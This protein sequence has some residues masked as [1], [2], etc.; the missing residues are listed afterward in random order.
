R[1]ELLEARGLAERAAG[2][3]VEAIALH[4]RAQERFV[5]AGQP[6]LAAKSLINV[7]ANYQELEDLAAAKRAYVEAIALLDAA[8]VPPSYRNR[9]T[10]ERNLGLLA[11]AETDAAELA[12]GIPHFEF[13]RAHGTPAEASEALSLLALMALELEDRPAIA[14]RAEEILELLAGEAVIDPST[15]V[16][17]RRAAGLGLLS[18]EDPRGEELLRAAETEA[19]ELSPLLDFNLQYNW[20]DQLELAERCDEALQRRAALAERMQALTPEQRPDIF[21][22]WSAAGPQYHCADP[23]TSPE[24]NPSSPE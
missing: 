23:S 16:E 6:T 13:V 3:Q 15:R 14:R 5:A 24:N 9:L 1:A 4:R 8:G 22:E 17:L 7:G 2:R 19:E 11:Y 21:A 10:L 20:I 12:A 18:L